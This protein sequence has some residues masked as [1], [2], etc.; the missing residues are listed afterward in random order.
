MLIAK[1]LQEDDQSQEGADYDEYDDT[2][3]LIHRTSPMNVNE[4]ESFFMRRTAAQERRINS[5]KPKFPVLEG[6]VVILALTLCCIL[7]TFWLLDSLKDAVFATIV[8]MEYQPTAKIVSV[9]S[10]LV[11][12]VCL[13]F[14][15][16]HSRGETKGVRIFYYVGVP[17]FVAFLLLG[18]GLKRH[19][20]LNGNEDH[21][22][23]NG[24]NIDA[25]SEV[26]KLLGYFAYVMI[27]SYGSIMVATFWAFTNSTLNLEAAKNSYGII[28]AVAQVGAIG[29]STVATSAHAVGVPALF[30]IGGVGILVAMLMVTVYAF[31][32]LSPNESD[33]LDS[34][35]AFLSQE[36]DPVESTTKS[37]GI[38]L[39]LR[40][41]YLIIVLGVSCLYEV[42]LTVMD[43]EMKLVG[44][45]AVESSESAG[46]S[47][48]TFAAFMGSF[49]IATNAL[50]LIL[51]FFGFSFLMRK[52]G[53]RYSIRVYPLFLVVGAF[54]SFLVPNLWVLFA[55]MAILK[56]MT[57]SIYDPCKE[58][59]YVPTSNDVKFKAKFWI[60]VV[61]ARLAKAV[62]SSINSLSEA[63]T[64]RLIQYGCIPSLLTS[65]LLLL[66]SIHAGKLFEEIVDS[67]IV[68]GA[69]ENTQAEEEDMPI[70]STE[71][72]REEY[73]GVD[74]DAYEHMDKKKLEIVT[75]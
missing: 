29:G 59:L 73:T 27:E 23:E 20:T 28:I 56:A 6:R 69:E 43:Y 1:D 75:V 49:G 51:S 22:G 63:N 61:G 54:L 44:L 45:A 7:S 38:S 21:S 58:I 55:S 36:N 4:R 53:L 35:L 40:H 57:Y 34:T 25:H 9:A 41:N 52:F 32:F 8:G 3:P 17:Y 33:A 68:I 5:L 12:V 48:N 11:F 74:E 62:G 60:D 71:L 14:L 26:W 70:Y 67:G 47:S 42:V 19:P 15:N 30:F 24:D 18:F 10:T 72:R 13:E 37:S 31:F 2:K 50:S 16:S 66:V 39:I 64:R 65:L 46:N